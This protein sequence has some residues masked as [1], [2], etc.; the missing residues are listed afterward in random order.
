M[1]KQSIEDRLKALQ[2]EFASGQK[3]LAELETRQSNTRAALLRISGAIQVLEEV[4][5]QGKKGSV[6]EALQPD[7]ETSAVGAV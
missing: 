3:L 4:L 7:P 2:S 5:G 1:D 6:G